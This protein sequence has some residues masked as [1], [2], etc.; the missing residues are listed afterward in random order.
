MGK[1][2]AAITGQLSSNVGDTI[3]QV[4]SIWKV[5]PAIV[6]EKQ[7]EVQKM[8]NDLTIK[9]LDSVNTEIQSAADIIKTEAQ[10]QSWIPRN[11]RPLLLL[12]WG[13]CLT[14][15]MIAA[16]IVYYWS[17]VHIAA[18]QLDPWV[19]KLTAIGYTGYVTARTWEKVKDKDN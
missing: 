3:K 11:V 12:L 10:S 19:Y 17:G 1:L 8:A 4:A 7:T 5:D 15:N 13:L 16:I 18:M 6:L 2:L 14:F 9:T